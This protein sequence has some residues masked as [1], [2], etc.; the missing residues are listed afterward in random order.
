M[1][2]SNNLTTS[3]YL[4]APVNG[5]QPYYNTYTGGFKGVGKSCG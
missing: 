5:V 1:I 3:H 4:A 2:I